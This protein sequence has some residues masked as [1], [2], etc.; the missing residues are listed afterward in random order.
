M[1]YVV[2]FYFTNPIY[3]MGDAQECLDNF[4]PTLPE[5]VHSFKVEIED[6]QGGKIYFDADKL[7]GTEQE[8]IKN[9]LKD[10]F[11]SGFGLIFERQPFAN[12]F[13][14]GFAEGSSFADEDFIVS[15][16]RSRND[17]ELRELFTK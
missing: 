13:T 11:Y 16:I 1:K 8:S 12:H 6:E 2:D 5:A 15:S 14:V 7:T 3:A 9:T 17:F 4:S 10:E